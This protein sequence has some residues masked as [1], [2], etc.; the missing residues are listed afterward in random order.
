M[1]FLKAA[2]RVS[3]HLLN[4]VAP[5]KAPEFATAQVPALGSFLPFEHPLAF[6][7]RELFVLS[8]GGLG[9]LYELDPVAH[10]VLSDEDLEA[11]V[12]RLGNAFGGFTDPDL[13]FQV[14]FES[15]PSPDFP[16]PEYIKAPQNTAQRIMKARIERMQA[17][18]AEGVEGLHT[19]RRRA[20]I[21]VRVG[22]RRVGLIPQSDTLSRGA[23]E[24]YEAQNAELTAIAERFSN[25]LSSLEQTFEHVEIPL[26]RVG[27][28]D[29]LI[30]LRSFL[31]SARFTREN[32]TF[33]HPYNPA[34]RIA[35]QIMLDSVQVTPGTIELGGEDTCEVL[36]WRDQAPQVYYG[37]MAYLLRIKE[38]IQVVVTFRPTEL[39]GTFLKENNTKAAT[40]AVSMREGNDLFSV[41]KR[42]AEG[43]SL[44]CVSMHV[45]CRNVGAPAHRLKGKS[46]ALRLINALYKSSG[47]PFLQE[48]WA[49]PAVFF[50]CL[51]FCYR[52]DS[53]SFVKRERR[54]LSATLGAYLPVLGGFQGSTHMCSPL[55]SRAGDP[56][57]LSPWDTEYMAH[58]GLLARSRGGKSFLLALILMGFIASNPKGHIWI[59]DKR[60]SYLI[61]ARVLGESGSGYSISLPPKSFPNIFR[62]K[63]D[64]ERLS[65]LA[66]MITASISIVSPEFEIKSEHRTIVTDALKATYAEHYLDAS[67]VYKEGVIKRTGVLD[68]IRTPR[69]SDIVEHFVECAKKKGI[70]TEIAAELKR[71][72]GPFLGSGQYAKLFDQECWE[73][74]EEPTPTVTLI[75]LQGVD[76]DP[77][78]RSLTAMVCISEVIRQIN[79]P[80]NIGIPGCLVV[81]ELGVLCSSGEEL[82]KFVADAWKTLGKNN[83]ACFGLT[84][85]V[86]DYKRYDGARAAWASSP[87]KLILPLEPQEI[88]AAFTSDDDGPA[89]LHDPRLAT[90][91]GSLRLQKGVF[92]QGIWLSSGKPSGSFTYVPTGYDY[93]MA[94]S[95]PCEIRTVEKV[96]EKL[97]LDNWFDAVDRL[98]RH[99]PG[100]FWEGKEARE[101]TDEELEN[102]R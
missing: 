35:D 75:D 89:L 98:A 1:S 74:P 45:I 53:G 58:L 50:F 27:V 69:L 42:L 73:E 83:V 13:V 12:G 87:T 9:A 51:P 101:I 40:D 54:V 102:L 17:M 65:V 100:G 37:M 92:S 44:F 94:A 39:T 77:I 30:L 3:S 91:I 86:R 79:R 14:I 8:D 43:E 6:D 28:A 47:V 21:C 71:K 23:I 76:G 60:T 38:P 59:I 70:E 68:R 10:E 4:Y 81:E 88:G 55:H 64:N 95:K 11:V 84:N 56:I 96:R 26:L 97:G 22:G 48:K 90:I 19:M 16:T 7:G 15:R 33:H 25:I 5:L 46:M 52:Y 34:Y 31:H 18:A 29:L 41:Q 80:E 85:E 62:G 72:L 67:T 93:W 57:Y 66:Y 32:A 2:R 36:S 99:Q 82:S 61:L 49:A 24:E 63:P 78:L 20:Y